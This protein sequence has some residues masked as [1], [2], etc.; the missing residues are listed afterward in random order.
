MY[1]NF[2]E[3][4][5]QGE[6]EQIRKE[7]GNGGIPS[8]DKAERGRKNAEES[9]DKCEKS[10]N[11]GAGILS[12]T[13]SKELYREMKRYNEDLIRFGQS[14]VDVW[15]Y[16]QAPMDSSTLNSKDLAVGYIE[17]PDMEVRMPLFL[18][19]SDENLAR[20]AAVL[21]ETSMPI[22]GES[23]NCVIAGHRGWRGSAYFQYIENMKMGSEVYITN[24]WD[25][26]I[27]K[28]TDT[29]IVEPTDGDSIM[30]REGRDM[31]TLLSCHPYT[32]GNSPYRYLVF[33]ERAKTAGE[34]R[35]EEHTTAGVGKS[36]AQNIET[37]GAVSG[38]MLFWES[39]LRIALPVLLGS[40]T[41]VIS[42]VRY[43]RDRRHKDNLRL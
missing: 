35:A 43:S 18:G 33:C 32:L 13:A 8:D 9:L 12:G 25:T 41:V 15:S 6:V 37:E 39:C 1:P 24:P 29:E 23:T 5:M 11:E 36:R 40:I 2:R 19:A 16:E 38:S 3:W 28:V 22:G 34:K 10:A 30:I 17:I 14:I 27:Y 20:G 4:K 21:S 7:L 31:V 42:F 26:L